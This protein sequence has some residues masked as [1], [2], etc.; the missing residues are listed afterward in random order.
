ML[1]QRVRDSALIGHDYHAATRAELHSRQFAQ[2]ER[3]T[4][5]GYRHSS[6]NVV[7]RIETRDRWTYRLDHYRSRRRGWVSGCRRR[8]RRAGQVGASVI[9]E[10]DHMRQ[11]GVIAQ[12]AVFITGNVIDLADGCKHFRL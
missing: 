1:R 8:T 12:L 11:G 6:W 2:I 9:H 3:W 5:V 10:P 4:E 7:C